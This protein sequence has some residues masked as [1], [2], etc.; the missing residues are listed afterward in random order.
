MKTILETE[1][2]RLR[3]LTDHDFDAVAVML[4]NP[5]V[6]YAWE[7]IFSDDEIR[8]WIGRHGEFYRE[9]GYGYRLAVDK[10]SG[11]AVG[12][13]G[14]LPEEVEGRKHLGIGWMLAEA[15]WHRGYA[16]EGARG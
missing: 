13:I 15:H 16:V 5:H 12:Q 11:E 8:G 9:Y 7:R 6:M 4:R 14:L 3:E 10:A 1:R 2:L